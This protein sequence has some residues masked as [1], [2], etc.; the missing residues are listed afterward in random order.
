M[1]MKRWL[2][3]ATLTLKISFLG[4]SGLYLDNFDTNLIFGKKKIRIHTVIKAG[5]H[6]KE[7]EY[8]AARIKHYGVKLHHFGSVFSLL[9]EAVLGNYL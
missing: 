3:L 1:K 4:Y 5:Q 6:Q 8:A 2:T 9:S 7:S